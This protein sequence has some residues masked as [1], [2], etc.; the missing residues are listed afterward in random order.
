MK[1]MNANVAMK[2]HPLVL[3]L[4]A[5]LVYSALIDVVYAAEV[6]KW[7]DENGK[8]HFGD[9]LSAPSN[10]QKIDVKPQPML[11][12]STPPTQ[13]Q[14]GTLPQATPAP[15]QSPQSKSTPADPSQ[16]R[17]GCK[18]LIDQIANVKPGTNWQP[19]YQQFNATCP[20]IAYE[21]NNYQ[22]HPENNKCEWVKR[23]GN[24]VLHT[25]NYQ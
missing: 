18:E 24:N 25:N 13:P 3:C 10:G 19:L 12:Q 2:S 1:I 16:I 8:V 21:C 23:T 17:P 15:I 5:C 11:E 7:T 4:A 9:R 6:Y 22:T 14:S 20:G